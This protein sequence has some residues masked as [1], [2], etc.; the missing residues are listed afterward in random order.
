VLSDP[1]VYSSAAEDPVVTS[2]VADTPPSPFIADEERR[3]PMRFTAELGEGDEESGG[4]GLG[5]AEDVGLQAQGQWEQ[6]ERLAS[7]SAVAEGQIWARQHIYFNFEGH[8]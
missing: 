8:V 4:A 2:P 3:D 6:G 1:E 5:F 7:P